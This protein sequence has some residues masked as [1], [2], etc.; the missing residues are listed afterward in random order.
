MTHTGSRPRGM[1]RLVVS[2]SGHPPGTRYQTFIRR[3][4]CLAGQYLGSRRCSRSRRASYRYPSAPCHLGRTRWLV[5]SGV[6]A[7]PETRPNISSKSWRHAGSLRPSVPTLLHHRSCSWRNLLG[8]VSTQTKV[9]GH[10][11]ARLICG[12]HFPYRRLILVLQ[13]VSARGR[14]SGNPRKGTVR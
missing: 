12:L 14:S 4:G 1:V 7:V 9:P 10:E 2:N 6:C 5:T 8:V 3:I 11:R 13:T